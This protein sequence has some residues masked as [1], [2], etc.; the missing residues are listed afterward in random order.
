MQNN[1]P[2]QRASQRSPSLQRRERIG[3]E[4][5]SQKG[6]LSDPKS[7]D[8]DPDNHVFGKKSYHREIKQPTIPT[9][10]AMALAAFI[11]SPSSLPQSA[12]ARYQT[13]SPQPQNPRFQI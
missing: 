10:I 12:V 9:P 4:P 7:F 2:S 8:L 13:N 3:E 1:N 11:P 6:S 5:E